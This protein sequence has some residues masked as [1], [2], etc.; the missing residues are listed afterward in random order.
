METLVSKYGYWLIALGTFFEGEIILVWGGFWAQ[1]GRLSLPLVMAC[2]YAGTVLGEFGLYCLG[3]W[4]GQWL[5]QRVGILRRNLPRIQRFS[6]RFG[7]WGIFIGRYFYSVRS[8]GNIFYG[9]SR[10]PW[11]TFIWATLLSCA[12][13]TVVVSLA[14][15]LFGKAATLVL[16]EIKRYEIYLLAAVVVI[17]LVAYLVRSYERDR[18]P[19][20]S[21][22]P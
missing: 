4:Q 8:V 22:L 18:I 11:G 19:R 5:F 21:D 20:L 9:M 15:Y 16:D 3:R 10:M 14:G 13:W 7:T 12:I 1:L 6:E 17:F 2:A